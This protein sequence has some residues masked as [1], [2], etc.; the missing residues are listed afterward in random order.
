M[1]AVP[2]R[3]RVPAVAGLVLVALSLSV[4]ANAP[5]GSSEKRV[6]VTVLDA[7]TNKP[8]TGLPASAFA[9]REDNLDRE[10]VSVAPATDPMSLVVLADT[11]SAFTRFT[12][13][14]RLSTQSFIKQFMGASPGSSVALWEFGGSDIPIVNFTTDEGRLELA[15]GRLFPKGTLSDLDFT[16][17]GSAITHGQDITASNLVEAIDSAAKQL[18]KRPETRRVIFSF[19]SDLSVEASKLPGQMVQDDVQKANASVFAVSLQEQVANGPLR[20]NVLNNLCPYS[21][22]KRITILDIAA[23]ESAL[24][25]VADILTSQYVVTY[26]RPSGT[27]RQVLVGVRVTGV[28]ANTARW[29]PK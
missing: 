4:S 9:I 3:L 23:L 24:K 13:D 18:A 2:S 8:V 5:Q 25:N 26:R 12:R 14:L 16:T 10:I 7:Q 1:T 22:G 11:T 15:A 27:A 28:A 6:F 19:N 21:G 17:T 29:A 20:D